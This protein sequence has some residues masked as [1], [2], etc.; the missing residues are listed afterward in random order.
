MRELE[1]KE[2]S[3]IIVSQIGE[4]EQEIESLKANTAPVEPDRAI[5]RLTRMDAIQAKEINEAV[6]RRAKLKLS[7][8]RNALG[9]LENPD[10]GDCSVC[11]EPIPMERMRLL[12]ES[13][14]CVECATGSTGR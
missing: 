11:E 9:R 3:E 14:R 7:K 12:P 8:L 4:L 1:R 6:L 5:G 2:I 13:T 10:F